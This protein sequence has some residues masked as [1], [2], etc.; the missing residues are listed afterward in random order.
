LPPR[1]PVT[2]QTLKPLVDKWVEGVTN[3]AYKYIQP[4]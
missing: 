1:D 2:L 4:R 3:D